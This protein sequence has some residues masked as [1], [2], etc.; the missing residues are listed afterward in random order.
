LRRIG[1]WATPPD[2]DRHRIVALSTG[3]L[4]PSHYLAVAA[5]LGSNLSEVPVGFK[6]FVDG[7]VDGAYGFGG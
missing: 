3:L 5:D 2:Y 6:W 4:K 7:L 1:A